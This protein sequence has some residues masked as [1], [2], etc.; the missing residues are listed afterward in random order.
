M[1]LRHDP[2]SGVLKGIIQIAGAGAFEGSLS[3]GPI[4]DILKG[5]DEKF[6]ITWMDAYNKANKEFA[7]T[8]K[9]L[10]KEIK[11]VDRKR[12][13]TERE[14]ASALVTNASHPPLLAWL[15]KNKS[16][17]D[18]FIRGVYTYATARSNNSAKY[19]IA[20]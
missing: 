10:D 3:A 19:V 17:S 4:S 15:N 20:K 14:T 5:L 7:V 16:R 11:S 8:K 13:D 2:S 12:Y 9:V 1:Q 18:M 6:S